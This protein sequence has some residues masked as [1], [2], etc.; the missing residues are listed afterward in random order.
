MASVAASVSKRRKP[1]R[2]TNAFGS[3]PMGAQPSSAIRFVAEL[4]TIENADEKEAQ[5]GASSLILNLRK[6][7]LYLRVG[8]GRRVDER[9]SVP[10]HK[11]SPPRKALAFSPARHRRGSA[12]AATRVAPIRACCVPPVAYSGPHLLLTGR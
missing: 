4:K 10:A 5:R 7:E 9:T 1:P 11:R 2:S 6:A 3:S 12:V 8:P